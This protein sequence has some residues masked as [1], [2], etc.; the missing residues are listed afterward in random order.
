[1]ECTHTIIIYLPELFDGLILLYRAVD[2]LAGTG[3][4]NDSGEL[5]AIK[6]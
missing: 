1:M 2:L 5:K 3:M 6:A 4:I